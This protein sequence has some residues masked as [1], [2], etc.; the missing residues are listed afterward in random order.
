M[1]IIIIIINSVNHLKVNGKLIID[2]NEVAE[3]LAINLFKKILGR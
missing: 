1:Y 3:A 2:K